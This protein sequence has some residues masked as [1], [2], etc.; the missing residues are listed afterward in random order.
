MRGGAARV[1]NSLRYA[2][3]IE[4]GDLFAEVKILHQRRAAWSG[5]QG[6]LVVGNL[7]ALIPAHHLAGFDGVEREVGCLI[8]FPLEG[9]FIDGR[10]GLTGSASYG[11]PRAAA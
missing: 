3:V 5:L 9:F 11:R 2:L 6:V 7:D 1:D 10:G 4:M 8:G